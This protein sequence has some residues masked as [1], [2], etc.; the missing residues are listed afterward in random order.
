MAAIMAAFFILVL[1]D[2]NMFNDLNHRLLYK[3][4]QLEQTKAKYFDKELDLC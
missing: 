2:D 3:K 1:K 4:N